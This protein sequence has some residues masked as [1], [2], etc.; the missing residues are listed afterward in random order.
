MRIVERVGPPRWPDP[1]VEEEEGHSA[2]SQA[3]RV[4]ASA[5]GVRFTYGTVSRTDEMVPSAR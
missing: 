2:A 3:A 5:S 4:S 1:F